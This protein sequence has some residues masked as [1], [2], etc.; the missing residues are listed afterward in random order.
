VSNFY[1]KLCWFAAFA[2]CVLDFAKVKAQDHRTDSLA[3]LLANQ[4][5][6]THRVSV[7]LELA[8]I[9]RNNEF[10]KALDYVT[11]AIHL[12]DSLQSMAG[13]AEA[14]VLNS[15]LQNALGAYE[16]SIKY[17]LESHELFQKIGNYSGMGR[18]LMCMGLVQNQLRN[19]Q[20]AIATLNEAVKCYKTA[21]DLRGRISAQHNLAVVY[22]AIDDTVQARAQYKRNLADLQGTTF[23]NIYAGTYNNL[24]NLF[25]PVKQGDSAIHYLEIALEYKYKAKRPSS[26]GIGNT[27]MNIA[28][29]RLARGELKLAEAQLLVADSLVKESKEKVRALELAKLWGQLYYKMGRYKESAEY[30]E[31][32]TMLQDSLFTP[33]MTEQATRME[34]AYSS[35]RQKK[36]IEL[37]NQAAALET[38]EKVK[39]RWITLAIAIG[40]VLAALLLLATVF[41]GRERSRILKLLQQKNEEIRRQQQEI[42]LQNQ[43]LS[44]QNKRLEDLNREKD[45]LIGIVAH[46]IRAPLNRSTA[47]AELIS[48]IGNL[49]AEQEKYVAM[50]R[51]VSEEGGRLIQDL[52]ELNT[53]ES[54]R[55]NIDILPL[56]VADLVNHCLSGFTKPAATKRITVVWEPRTMIVQTD[57]RLMGRI[58]DNL[59][60]NALKF[61]ASGKSIE[62]RLEE[63]ATEHIIAIQDQGPGISEQDQRRMFQKFQ[64]LSARPTGG[65]SS[66]GLGLSIVKVLAE[67]LGAT[68]VLDSKI[69]EG[70]TFR[71]KVPKRG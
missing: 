19:H 62:I 22:A 27:K 7:L 11:E 29:V 5:L 12:A 51:K 32:Q 49:S 21:K 37:L 28:R 71:V 41:R 48:S 2:F 52:L 61:T 4:P 26:A 47:L 70:S 1:R 69:G 42:L 33:Q 23:W 24:G 66:T 64:R 9:V 54:G 30:F 56:N 8:S 31:Q 59:I 36:E 25:D 3:A 18:A 57:E 17:S 13:L 65:E 50:I 43:A 20:K 38:S 67:R 39:W 45:G 34:A 63:S 14:K 44:L 10:Q 40:F 55:T 35:E 6:D 53:Y 60:S 15:E 46:D 68:I 16:E 58:L